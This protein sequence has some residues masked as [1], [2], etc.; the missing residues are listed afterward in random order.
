MKL[1]VQ[2]HRMPDRGGLTT[3]SVRYASA[4]VRCAA[5]ARRVRSTGRVCYGVV[6]AGGG[7][8]AHLRC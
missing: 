8:S 1:S 3:G 4:A 5:P 6:H 2:L 7:V